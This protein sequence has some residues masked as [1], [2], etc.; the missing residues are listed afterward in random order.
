MRQSPHDGISVLMRRDMREMISLD[1][2][3]TR[4]EGH[5][6]QTRKRTLTRH[7]IYQHLDLGSPSLQNSEKYM[8]VV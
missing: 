6:V 2:M 1:H 5:H 8:F 4:Q 7:I 3:R